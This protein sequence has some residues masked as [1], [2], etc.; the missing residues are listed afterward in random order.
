FDYIPARAFMDA[1][2][3]M[4]I[5]SITLPD[6]LKTLKNSCFY[7]CHF[8]GNLILPDSLER[9]CA[10][11]LDC[12]V[13]GVFRLPPKV[14]NVSSL[15]RSENGKAEIILPE[16]MRS[17]TPESIITDHLHIP[18]TLRECHPRWYSR[19]WN[20]HSITIAPGNPYLIVRDDKLV[21]LL[22]EKKAK[23]K[24]MA[25]LS[26]NA[27]LDTAFS[28][29]GLEIQK[30]YDGKTLTVSL[31]D[32]QCIYFRLGGT[33]TPARA[34]QAADIARRFEVLADGFPKEKAQLHFGRLYYVPSKRCLFF[35]AFNN[36]AVNIELSIEGGR[37]ELMETFIL[38]QKFF[39]L[40]THQVKEIEKKYGRNHLRFSFI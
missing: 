9:I 2:S 5:K 17:F 30:Q 12:K 11:A 3:E 35:Y 1:P 19:S 39:S 21:S 25:E 7:H 4:R 37:D 13:D 31:L 18:S 6:G 40:V 29:T 32:R 36:D 34:E 20:V 23:L 28:G 14:K 38:S 22:D 10:D 33:M 27:H 8:E 24:K 26:W 15:P 16:G